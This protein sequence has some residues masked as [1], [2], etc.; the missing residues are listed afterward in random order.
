MIIRDAERKETEEILAIA[1]R[2]WDGWDFIPLLINKWFEEGGLFVAEDNGEIV[3]V[4]KT[5]TLSQGNLW[6]EGIRVRE[7]LRGRGIG[8]ALAN[9]QLEEAKKQNPTSIRLSTAEVNISSIKVITQMGFKKIHEFGYME[10][11]DPHAHDPGE[12]VQVEKD[13]DTIFTYIRK[14]SYYTSAKG[15]FPWSWIFRDITPAL[16]ESI[17]QD[18]RIFSMK[19]DSHI[20]GLLILLPHRYSKKTTEISFIDGESEKIIEY[21]FTF[22]QF[23]TQKKGHEREIFYSPSRKTREIA[24]HS[25]FSFPYDFKN[26]LV[27]ELVSG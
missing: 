26:V 18:E 6:F 23:Y 24:I 5:T 7:D 17:I 27:Y 20:S 2:T 10:L 3:G 22:A 14:S 15:L 12:I 19:K 1:S 13:C 11:R 8:K 16:I 9:F 25:G 4:T 21:L